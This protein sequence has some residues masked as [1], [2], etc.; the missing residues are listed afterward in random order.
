MGQRKAKTRAAMM[1]TDPQQAN[2]GRSVTRV[3]P[4]NSIHPQRIHR[5]PSP[6]RSN[7]DS[8]SSREQRCG[9]WNNTLSLTPRNVQKLCF[10]IINMCYITHVLKNINSPRVDRIGERCYA[11]PEKRQS[12]PFL[13]TNKYTF[14]TLPGSPLT[15]RIG[16]Q[17]NRLRDC[18]KR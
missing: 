8:P 14:S 3:V 9:C 13:S 6:V 15:K 1:Q 18:V 7:G 2:P 10:F 12:D 16:E 4:N 5:I 17:G 11:V